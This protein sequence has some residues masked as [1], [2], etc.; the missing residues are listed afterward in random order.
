MNAKV[1]TNTKLALILYRFNLDKFKP[2][3]KQKAKVVCK[4]TQRMRIMWE[5]ICQNEATLPLFDEDYEPKSI[6]ELFTPE[7]PQSIE[8]EQPKEQTKNRHNRGT[9]LAGTLVFGS[10]GATS[11]KP[12]LRGRIRWFC[13]PAKRTSKN[14]SPSLEELKELFWAE[15]LRNPPRQRRKQ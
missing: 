7:L 12:P 8:I 2:I 13:C 15:E 9:P 11:Q 5:R 3:W 10:L 6:A 14:K 1:I 4:H